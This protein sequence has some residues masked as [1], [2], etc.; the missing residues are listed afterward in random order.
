MREKFLK[1]LIAIEFSYWRKVAQERYE[2]GIPCCASCAEI[3]EVPDGEDRAYI[4]LCDGC[5][6]EMADPQYPSWFGDEI[7]KGYT[8][9]ISGYSGVSG[10]VDGNLG[11]YDIPTPEK[12]PF[13][14]RLDDSS[15]ND[16]T[17]DEAGDLIPR[18]SENFDALAGDTATFPEAI[19][20]NL[21]VSPAA[22]LRKRKR[23]AGDE[24]R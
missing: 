21:Q 2:R 1:A 16:N 19:A 14:Y 23:G 17:E 18:D 12:S 24:V 7:T 9:R 10:S 6:L 22:L 15:S 11:E 13:R 3:L 20:R 8:N 4:N 5:D